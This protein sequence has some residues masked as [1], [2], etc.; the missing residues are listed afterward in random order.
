MSIIDAFIQRFMPKRTITETLMASMARTLASAHDSEAVMTDIR[1]ANHKTAQFLDGVRG[2][3]SHAREK[4]RPPVA[5]RHVERITETASLMAALQKSSIYNLDNQATLFVDAQS[6]ALF[7]CKARINEIVPKGSTIVIEYAYRPFLKA[8]KHDYQPTSHELATLPKR[9]GLMFQWVEKTIYAGLIVQH[10]SGVKPPPIMLPITGVKCKS[11]APFWKSG[12]RFT[13]IKVPS[14][15]N[16]HA[17]QDIMDG[18]ARDVMEE[19]AFGLTAVVLLKSKATPLFC[20][21]ENQSGF[22][23]VAVSLPLAQ[24]LH[25]HGSTI[26]RGRDR[27]VDW[28]PKKPEVK[29]SEQAS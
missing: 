9:M 17:D 18:F 10:P 14:F 20:A 13:G 11:D 19:L 1:T 23:P 8:A 22:G 15:G 3:P 7:D 5:P 26:R 2:L 6:K 27:K 28:L 12:F 25:R 29:T 4:R 21:A 16:S 24:A